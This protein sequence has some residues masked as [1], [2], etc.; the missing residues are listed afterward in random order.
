MCPGRFVSLFLLNPK[1]QNPETLNP[2]HFNPKPYTHSTPLPRIVSILARMGGRF[3]QSLR[4]RDGVRSRIHCIELNLL[5]F[6]SRFQARRGR[7]DLPRCVAEFLK[8]SAQDH[9]K[10][11]TTQRPFQHSH[12]QKACLLEASRSLINIPLRI[13]TSRGE[14]KE[15]LEADEAG[16]SREHTRWKLKLSMLL[17]KHT[18][19]G[20]ES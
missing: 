12:T 14:A 10:K 16:M 3:H 4:V 6:G 2:K 19:C 1:P 8:P 7:E 11:K 17:A 9:S 13:P 5:G 15:I 18:P 20:V